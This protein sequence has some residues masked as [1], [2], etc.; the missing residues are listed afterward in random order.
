[1]KPTPSR[2]D[3]VQ[4]TRNFEEKLKMLRQAAEF[5]EKEMTDYIGQNT[6][7][8]DVQDAIMSLV[9]GAEDVQITL[10]DYF[11]DA[12]V[13]SLQTQEEI[14]DEE[15]EERECIE[16]NAQVRND[17]CNSIRF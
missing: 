4:A 1:M 17:Y 9:A 11:R 7:G 5:I 8:D 3:Q 13:K 14:E 16:Y 2:D 10:N 6:L 15:R 12:D